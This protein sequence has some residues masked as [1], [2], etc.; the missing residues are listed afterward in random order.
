[1]L[2]VYLSDIYILLQEYFGFNNASG[3]PD[4]IGTLEVPDV[5]FSSISILKKYSEEDIAYKIFSRTP[6][7]DSLLDQL[8]R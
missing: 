8:F 5:P 2:V 3:I 6:A 7:D 4:L 1:M